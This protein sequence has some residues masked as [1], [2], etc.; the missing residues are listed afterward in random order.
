MK[1]TGATAGSVMN[2]PFARKGQRLIK[3]FT[4]VDPSCWKTRFP[5]DTKQR[6][7]SVGGG[8]LCA[9]RSETLRSTGDI[10]LRK[11]KTINGFL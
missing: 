6:G 1:E 2:N 9:R 8:S 5:R 11:Y 10:H 7:A 4:V 3:A